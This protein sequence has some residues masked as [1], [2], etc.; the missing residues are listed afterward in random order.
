MTTAPDGTYIATLTP[1][2]DGRVGIYLDDGGAGFIFH[3]LRVAPDVEL[4]GYTSTSSVKVQSAPSAL[5]AVHALSWV[6]TSQGA[7]ASITV[8]RD[9][10]TRMDVLRR[11][12][13]LDTTGHRMR[14][15]TGCQ[16]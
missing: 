12:W 2:P 13:D 14:S 3:D 1:E 11:R 8:V 9:V 4:V 10:V 7:S 16:R 6:V 15:P 5:R